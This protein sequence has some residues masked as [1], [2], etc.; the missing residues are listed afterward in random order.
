[1]ATKE[2]HSITM[3]PEIWRTLEALRRLRGQSISALIEDAVLALIKTKG[4]NP[5]YVKI[6][7]TAPYC[8]DAENAELTQVLD[9]L[10]QEDLEIAEEYDL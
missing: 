7:A 3:T 10:T 8:D 4:Y 6:L 9:A 2:R 5:L 1:M